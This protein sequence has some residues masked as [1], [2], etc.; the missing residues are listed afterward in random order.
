MS[1]D[2]LMATDEEISSLRIKNDKDLIET[3]EKWLKSNSLEMGPNNFQGIKDLVSFFLQDE[4]FVP[5][6]VVKEFRLKMDGKPLI[7]K[8]YRFEKEF[9]KGVAKF[10]KKRL[11]DSNAIEFWQSRGYGSPAIW[12][13]MYGLYKLSKFAVQENKNIYLWEETDESILEK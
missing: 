2:F 13:A 11:D 10:E 4:D 3:I 6:E 1:F 12:C 5:K 9:I 8:I 7:Y